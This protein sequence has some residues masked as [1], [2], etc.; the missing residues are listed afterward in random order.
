MT[1]GPTVHHDDVQAVLAKPLAEQLLGSDVPARLAYTALDGDPRV[2]PIGFHWTGA[3]IQMFTVP[4]SAKVAALRRSPRVALTVDTAGFPPR[5]LLV[6]GAA[7]LAT[8]PG[9][10]DEYVEASRKVM[11]PEAMES[12]E[13]GVRALY[14]EMVRITVEPDW[15]KLLD[16]ETTIPSA[17]EQLIREKQAG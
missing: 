17:V 2:I 4:R 13:A 5:V 8:V 12:W 7:T 14:D 1:G 16:F 10:P 3:Q 9:V 11:P 15:A 6:R